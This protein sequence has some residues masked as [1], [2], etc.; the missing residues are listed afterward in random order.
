MPNRPNTFFKYMTAKVA[1][2]VLVNHKLRWSSPRLFDDP[3][4]VLRN[5]NLGFE[6]EEIIQPVVDEVIKLI[7]NRVA[8]G[9]RS[10]PFVEKN[11]ERLKKLNTQLD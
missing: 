1:K 3:F 2:E 9:I 10:T 4:D 6:I 7:Y 11:W 5:F 8:S